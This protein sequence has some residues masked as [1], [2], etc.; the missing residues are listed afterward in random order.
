MQDPTL[1]VKTKRSS[2]L[3]FAAGT[4]ASTTTTTT[5]ILMLCDS[6]PPVQHSAQI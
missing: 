5:L 4:T 3:K 6:L 2:L 1:F